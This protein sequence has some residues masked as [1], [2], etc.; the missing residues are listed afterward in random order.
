MNTSCK[1]YDTRF[2]EYL[3]LKELKQ[4]K[5]YIWML[6]L[7]NDLMPL[8]TIGYIISA[9]SIII[10]Y[11]VTN[12][13]VLSIESFIV[14]QVFTYIVL[15]ISIRL[16]RY[17]IDKIEMLK[18]IGRTRCSLLGNFVNKINNK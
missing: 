17:S 11:V 14:P 1:N 9:V 10:K 7:S 18:Y 8:A 13:I 12:D 4:L 15:I 2:I 5:R 3:S 6:K 16:G